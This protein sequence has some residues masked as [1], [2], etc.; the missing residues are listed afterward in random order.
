MAHRLPSRSDG[1]ADDSGASA[2]FAVSRVQGSAVVVADGEVDIYTSPGFRDALT[3]A[4]RS[5]ARIVVDL[6]AVTFSDSF[7]T[8]VI[9]ATTLTSDHDERNGSLCLVGP[10]GIVRKAIE[11]TGLTRPFPIYETVEEAVQQQA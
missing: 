8:G 5:S 1:P 2:K 9:A 6:A 11:I 4:A 3:E 7:A 10:S